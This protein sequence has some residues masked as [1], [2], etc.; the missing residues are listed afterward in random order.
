MMAESLDAIGAKELA[1]TKKT[2]AW[3]GGAMAVAL[4]IGGVALW[5][6]CTA[7]KTITN[8]PLDMGKAP[9]G[10]VEI[11]GTNA[12]DNAVLVANSNAVYTVEMAG[13]TNSVPAVAI[14]STNDT[15]MIE[16]T[17]LV[18]ARLKGGVMLQLKNLKADMLEICKEQGCKPEDVGHHF[19]GSMRFIAQKLEEMSPEDYATFDFDKLISEAMRFTQRSH[20]THVQSEHNG[21]GK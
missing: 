8:E 20:S 11:G 3:T 17:P 21:I 5:K 7:D 19:Q 6:Y 13:D 4:A 10:H 18:A 14:G 15:N 2:A 16:F 12:V 1:K 9:A